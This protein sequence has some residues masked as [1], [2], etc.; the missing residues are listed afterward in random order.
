MEHLHHI[1]GHG[2]GRDKKIL[3]GIGIVVETPGKKNFH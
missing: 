2:Q 1:W 3:K